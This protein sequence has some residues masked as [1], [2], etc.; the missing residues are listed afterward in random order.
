MSAADVPR[1]HSV[2]MVKP[3][4]ESIRALHFANTGENTDAILAGTRWPRAQHAE[5]DL[6]ER[7]V[8]DQAVGMLVAQHCRPR[9][10]GPREARGRSRRAGLRQAQAAVVV[11]DLRHGI[12][13]V[14]R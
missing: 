11:V 9:R 6:R 3:I 8:I 7:A 14:E 12:R 10:P 5:A 1:K 13:V 4:P 2:G